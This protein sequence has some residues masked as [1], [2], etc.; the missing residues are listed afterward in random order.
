[1]G[2][3]TT[4]RTFGDLLFRFG[5]RRAEGRTGLVDDLPAPDGSIFPTR[6][7]G[8]F[9]HYLGQTVA[10]T[11]LDLGPVVGDNVTFLGEELGCRLIVEDVFSDI[12]R[13]AREVQQ[14]QVEQ[15]TG[16]GMNDRLAHPEASADGVL[17]WDVFD[18]LDRPAAESLARQI[19]RVLKPGGT[20]FG[21][22]G[23]RHRPADC[24]T[25]YA[26]VDRE[27][28]E[29]RSYP[30]TCGTRRTWGSRDVQKLFDG[31][32]VGETYLLK[33]QIREMLFRKPQSVPGR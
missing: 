4:V 17:C 13:V 22:F 11:I 8:R 27:R 14:E 20:V 28:L 33:I 31:L 5:V 26:I 19:V 9:L 21:L 24:Y 32:T 1:M 25:K 6:G 3:A 29:H 7:L 30:A 18:Y 10:P 12:E 23:D 2:D 16:D 15:V